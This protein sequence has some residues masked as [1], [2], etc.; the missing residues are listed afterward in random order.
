MTHNEEL[1]QSEE[2]DLEQTHVKMCKHIKMIEC[3]PSIEKDMM[4]F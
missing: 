4:I 3:M 1:N 2:I